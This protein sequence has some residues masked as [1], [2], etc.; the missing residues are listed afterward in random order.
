MNGVRARLAALGLELPPPLELPP[1]QVSP[2][3]RLLRDGD[4]LYLSGNGPLWGG[5]VR[6]AG[7]LGADL[8]V[9]QGYEAARLTALNHVRTLVDEGIDLDRVRWLKAL[10][11]VNSAPDFVRQPAVVNGFSDLVLELWGPDRGAHSRSA[12]GMASLPMGIAVEIEAL[13]RLD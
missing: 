8:T 11:M 7:K 5:E 9:E 10:G 12:V 13:C 4:H 2:A 3:P 1:G 6:F